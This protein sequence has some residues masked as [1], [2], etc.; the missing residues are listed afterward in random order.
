MKRPEYT[1]GV[2]AVYRDY[3]DRWEEDPEHYQ[4]DSADL[5]RLA[6]LF[7]RD[8]LCSGYYQMHNGPEMIA[9]HNRKQEEKAAKQ[10]SAE[11]AAEYERIAA[12]LMET[13]LKTP[14]DAEM[15]LRLNEPAE[16]TLRTDILPDQTDPDKA[17]LQISI[18]GPVVEPA[19]KQP[20]T[21]ERIGQQLKK[22]GESP[23]EIRN[24]IITM[25][26]EP[27]F[28]PISRLNALRRDALAILE[29]KLL[30][31]YRRDGN[32]I[33]TYKADILRQNPGAPKDTD[34]QAQAETE[35]NRKQHRILWIQTDRPETADLIIRLAV[36]VFAQGQLPETVE[37]IGIDLPL[38]A[39]SPERI[40]QCTREGFRVR[41]SLPY[42]VRGN[43]AESL[44]R[45]LDAMK[46]E[47]SIEMPDGFLV[48]NLEGLG[49]LKDLKLEHLAVMDAGLFTWNN[50]ALA[51]Y[52]ESGFLR[53]T[54]PLEL[55]RSEIRHRDN[56]NSELI[57]Y[58]RAPMMISA[59]CVRKTLGK[60]LF[61][62][63]KW[64][65]EFQAEASAS[66]GILTLTDRKGA[67]FP[68]VNY[69]SACYNV[70][71][72][73]LPACIPGSWKKAADEAGIASFRIAFT[74]EQEAQIREV[75]LA[76]RDHMAGDTFSF[77]TTGG[78]YKRGVE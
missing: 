49:I 16:L 38:E 12:H 52:R 25:P 39:Y 11:A 55:N 75:M 22:T 74:T 32:T 5:Q 46:A 37:Q 18:L 34:R 30:E 56:H 67:A 61:P 59:Q 57:V 15:V 9:L 47:G 29:E 36:E 4:V 40:R 23:F 60:C 41:L 77:P 70:I 26:E 1:A 42:I 69:C 58:G 73:S 8:G 72:N 71:Y 14:C 20:T 17:D 45:K 44:R 66:G 68:V 19:A 63:R 65:V 24:L 13:Q 54:V 78:H 48:R 6:N 27:V 51:F 10:H 3:I 35:Q 76:A 7:N 62:K 43:A 64:P 33:S 2:T 50:E 31:Q 21:R 28:L 53:N